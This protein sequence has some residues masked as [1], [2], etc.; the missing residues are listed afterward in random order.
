[1]LYCCTAVSRLLGDNGLE[2]ELVATSGSID[3]LR[4]LRDGEVD[5]AFV[6][7]G[8]YDRI[9]DPDRV[10]RGIAALYLE[11]LWVI[12]RGDEEVSE[13]A[14]FEGQ[15]ISIGPHESGTET[16]ARIVLEVNGLT[17]ENSRLVSLSATDAAAQLEEGTVDAAFIVSAFESPVIQRLLD[18]HEL[19]LMS[20]RR[21]A[22]YARVFPYLVPIELAEGVLDLKD[23][24]PSERTAL[25]AP[26]ALLACGRDLHPRVVEQF[27]SAARQVH[28][29]GSLI[30]KPGRFPSLDGLDLPVHETAEAY[31]RSGESL[32]SRVVPY[33]A[34]LWVVRAQFLIIPILT[35]WIPFFKILPL[36]YRYRIGSL[37]KKHYAA[38]RDVETGIERAD[39]PTGLNEAVQALESLRDDMERLSRKI[40][41]YYQRDVY[42][43]RLHVSMVQDEARARLNEIHS[44][45]A[46][47]A[48]GD[49]A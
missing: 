15:T 8:T 25:L 3:N 22:A 2:L 37:L 38:L 31:L 7:S 48:S 26:S 9:D 19:R 20:F 23:N 28:S 43:W 35:L 49:P 32:I 47:G 33:W 34:L 13:L 10:I 30:E 14:D 12:Y 16:V 36:L 27:L 46:E 41:A 6:Q 24:T 18:N 44:D 4:R 39:S 29:P 17:D 21:H 11:P 45:L 1:M 5:A 40:P 42:H